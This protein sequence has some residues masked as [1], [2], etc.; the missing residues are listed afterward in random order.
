[1]LGTLAACG[2]LTVLAG[3][4]PTTAAVLDPEQFRPTIEGF[5]RD[6]Q[7]LYAQAV[8]NAAAWAFLRDRMPLFECPDA[9]VQRTWYFRWWTF[10]KHLKQ[11]PDGWVVTEFL[12]TV[13]WAGKHNT[14]SCAAGHHL[15]EG[16]W[17]R[18]RRPCDQY[19]SFWFRRGG[20]PRRYSF[21]AADALWQYA[22]VTGRFDLAADLLDDLVANYTAW[23][24]SRLGPDGLYWQVDGEDGMEVS[25]GGTGYR[26]TINTYQYGDALAIAH[27]ADRAGRAELAATYRA[28]AAR[29][30]ELV[31]TRLWDESAQFFKVLPRGEGAKLADVRELHGYTPWYLNLPDARYAVAWR[32]LTDPQGFAAPFG[33]TTCERRHP[34][35]RLS[36]EGHECQ[37]NG[38]SWPYSTAVTLTALANLLNGPA[39]DAIGVRDYFE[40]LRTYARSHRLKLDDGR[41]VPWI[42]E[43]LNPLTGDWIAR[44]R[45]KTWRNGTWDAG[46]G[47]VER[48][49][50]YNHSTFCDLVISGLV[51]LRPRP[52]DILEVNPLVPEGTW[53]WWCLDNLAY[54]DRTLTILFDR[55]GE[56]Y[57]RG[58]GLRVLCDGRELAA[59]PGLQRLTVPLPAAQAVAGWTKHP[60]SPVLGGDLGTCFDITVRREAEHYQMCFSWRPQKSLAV[61]DSADGVHW[62]APRIVLG[63]ADT[64][65][66]DDLNRPDLVRRD[67]GYHL[68]YTG[69]ARG[70]SQ[71][72]YA[73][74]ADGVTWSRRREPVLSPDQPWE[75]VAVMC[76]SVLWDAQAGLWRMWYSGGE[77]YEPDALGYATSPDGIRW[78]KHPTNPIFRP[79]PAIA[80]EQHKVT[81]AQVVKHGGEYLMFYIGFRDVHHAQIGLARSRDGITDW[82]RHPA[83]PLIRPGAGTWDADACYKPHAIWD[84]HRWL[85]WYNGRREH[86]EQIGLAL[87]VGEEL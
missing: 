53:D 47:G 31:Q 60:A 65:W 36:Y 75:R 12:P 83:N 70:H 6:D 19:A 46:K 9:D 58:A 74:S 30:K 62:S 24:Q 59:A 10:R 72:G 48:G 87:H 84:G 79:D 40:L 55:T 67:D 15:R 76:P 44:T 54:R 1:M 57:H 7:E 13:P 41:E 27:L 33:P 8:P 34:G 56:R 82:R 16:R 63:P 80:W 26:A 2:A 39:Q 22:L 86:V 32:Q 52:D 50:D 42:D 35:F 21:W 11:T 17:L 4:A 14:I 77:Q 66:E 38:P 5:N 81:A 85:L 49:Q 68:W 61:T 73:T 69:Q 28:K 18:D 78:T 23:E 45:L 64:G 37:W 29:L 71:I 43:N 25:V 51:G 3:G 20:E